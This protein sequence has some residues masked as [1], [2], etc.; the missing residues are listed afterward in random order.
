MLWV[1][2]GCRKGTPRQVIE[3]GIQTIFQAHHL[4]EAEIAGIATIDLKVHEQGLLAFCHDRSF[5]L[6]FFPKDRLNR[7]QVPHPSTKVSAAID[8][9]SVAEAA[10]ILAA[11]ESKPPGKIDPGTIYTV[12]LLVAKQIFLTE[13][14]PSQMTIAIAQASI[15]E[16]SS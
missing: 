15:S 6:L 1:G 11:S 12:E 9:E 14:S 3:Q 16:P 10:A 8:I 5:P 13:Q 2:V 7:V 4:S